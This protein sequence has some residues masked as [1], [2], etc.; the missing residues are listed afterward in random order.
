LW[1]TRHRT[2]QM[3]AVLST[4]IRKHYAAESQREAALELKLSHALAMERA[5][6]QHGQ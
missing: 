4:R 2:V 1:S 3:G 5:K 6:Q